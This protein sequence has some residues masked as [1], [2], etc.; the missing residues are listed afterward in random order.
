MVAQTLL[1]QKRM[2]VH[3]TVKNVMLAAQHAWYCSQQK[4]LYEGTWLLWAFSVVVPGS[5][6]EAR[7]I[8]FAEERER[9]DKASLLG[10]VTMT[11]AIQHVIASL[12][13]LMEQ[14]CHTT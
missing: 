10:L 2:V 6:N 13:N 4:E 8:L 1:G 3:P 11:M 12:D 9:P 5:E 7:W 14:Y